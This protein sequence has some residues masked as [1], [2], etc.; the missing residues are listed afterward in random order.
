[1]ACFAVPAAEAVI[2]TIVTKVAKSKEKKA[3]AAEVALDTAEKLPFSR[4][5]KWL[6]NMLWGGSAL[7]MFEHVWHGEIVPW[8][9]FLTATNDP[10]STAA[11]LNEMATAGVAMS[12]LVTAV[13][14]G[15]VAVSH[16]MEKREKTES[17]EN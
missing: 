13:W 1:M 7:L 11:M 14:G 10:A 3:G 15:M 2:T 16:V 12:L 6:S 8:A 9:P 17:A 4:K 5:L